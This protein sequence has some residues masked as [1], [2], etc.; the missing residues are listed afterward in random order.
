MAIPSGSGTEVLRSVSKQ[1]LNNT[2]ITISTK[3]SGS[4][5]NLGLNHILTILSIVV[6]NKEVTTAPIAIT[7]TDGSD[8]WS[9]L[10]QGGT[11]IPA[12][13]ATFVFNDKFILPSDHI[14][15]LYSTTAKNTDWHVTFIDQ[16]WT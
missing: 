6:T 16:D 14:L 12:P 5:F 8:T 11:I 2:N 15:T 1:N 7:M 9:I 10:H 3:A 4:T 13:Q